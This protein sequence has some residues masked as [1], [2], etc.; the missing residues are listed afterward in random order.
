MT[1]AKSL[2]SCAIALL[3]V[4]MCGA[5]DDALAQTPQ[6]VYQV[7]FQV[8]IVPTEKAARVRIRLGDGAK[9]VR[10]MRFRIDPER[11]RDLVADGELDIGE[12]WVE[13]RPPPGGGSL[14]YVFSIDHLRD[15]R[16]YDARAATRWAIFRGDMLV[17]AARVR[18]LGS[19]RSESRLYLQL[20]EGWSAAV[21]YPRAAAG[22]YRVSHRGRRFDRPTGW[23][24][25]GEIGVLRERIAGTRVSIAG[26]TGHRLRRMDLMT[27]L[28]WTLPKLRD[29]FGELP[30]RLLIVGAGDPMWRGGLSG[31]NSVFVHA[32]RPLVSED[33]SSPV[34]HELIHTLARAQAGK[35]GDWIVEGLAELYSIEI[36]RRSGSM[37][38][39]RY[40]RVTEGLERRARGA[41]KLRVK[42]VSGAKTAKAVLVLRALGDEVRDGS[43]GV[44]DL[45][46]VLRSLTREGKKLTTT[47]LQTHSEALAGRSLDAFFT[48]HVPKPAKR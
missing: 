30:D 40:A 20:P 11:H 10:W 39:E 36:L 35:G 33:G 7:D 24:V 6:A 8:R 4:W 5:S 32:D 9:V 21:P 18:T 29:L 45:D 42:S 48:R 16:S 41:G 28:H 46:D 23:M 17:P 12:E 47:R 14:R 19:A 38:E 27:L 15:E 34:L 13:W 25:L 26:P 44:Y 31:P 1:P 43:G 2:R 37:S 3:L 22:H